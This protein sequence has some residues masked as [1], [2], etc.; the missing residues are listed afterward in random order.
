MNLVLIHVCYVS[1]CET[2]MWHA[3]HMTDGVREGGIRSQN[4]ANVL[5][6]TKPWVLYQAV[7]FAH[8]Y[9]YL[10]DYVGPVQ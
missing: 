5:V 7:P 10:W 9:K 8:I 3:L 4:D 1:N 2:G 6:I